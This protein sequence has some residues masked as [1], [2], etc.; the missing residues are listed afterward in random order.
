MSLLDW[1][2]KALYGLALL[3]WRCVAVLIFAAGTALGWYMHPVIGLAAALL[4][5]IFLGAQWT[6]QET[7]HER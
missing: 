5:V 2:E 3:I 7:S 4:L 1:P 6:P